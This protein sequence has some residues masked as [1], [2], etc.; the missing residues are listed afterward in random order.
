[1]VRR[2]GE[3]RPK[4]R[5]STAGPR[6][7]V[8]TTHRGTRLDRSTS[9][10]IAPMTRMKSAITTTISTSLCPV[11]SAFSRKSLITPNSHLKYFDTPSTLTSRAALQGIARR[12]RHVVEGHRRPARPDTAGARR[13]SGPLLHTTQV[14]RSAG[15]P[16]RLDRVRDRLVALV[17][18][19]PVR[20]LGPER[21]RTHHTRHEVGAV[22]ADHGIRVTE[23][24]ARELVEVGRQVVDVQTVVRG[25][26][27]TALGR[28]GLLVGPRVGGQEGLEGRNLGTVGKGRHELTAAEDRLVGRVHRRQVEGE[29]IAVRG[30]RRALGPAVLVEVRGTVHHALTG[31]D[32]QAAVAPRGCRDGP[33]VAVTTVDVGRVL[34]DAADDAERL[35]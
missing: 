5:A 20:H 13:W 11:V 6:K 29:D 27:A 31:E 26:P 33:E 1:M 21:A 28:D 9:H 12:G 30:H 18:S 2:P 22:E 34:Q 17:E 14:M 7:P 25:H 15:R 4:V 10:R 3:T 35:D 24:A 8:I 32:R 19:E 16:G 23:D